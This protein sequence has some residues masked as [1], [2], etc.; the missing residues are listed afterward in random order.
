MTNGY[1]L[2]HYKCLKIYLFC[3][4]PKKGHVDFIFK[5]FWQL[6]ILF[7]QDKYAVQTT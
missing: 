4:E 2:N 5:L 6:N 7:A 1:A 3:I